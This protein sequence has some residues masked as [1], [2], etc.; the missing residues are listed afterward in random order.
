[1]GKLFFFFFSLNGLRQATSRPLTR[2]AALPLRRNEMKGP[3]AGTFAGTLFGGPLGTSAKGGER[4]EGRGG[5]LLLSQG[6]GLGFGGCNPVTVGPA[7]PES[8]ASSE[9]SACH[10]AP[11]SLR[12]PPGRNLHQVASPAPAPSALLLHRVLDVQPRDEGWSGWE[13]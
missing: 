8:L 1:M 12:R 3:T 2:L 6:R 4:A 10:R 7:A 9:L 13:T 5:P 11:P